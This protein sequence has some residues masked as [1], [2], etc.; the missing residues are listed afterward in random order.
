M[1]L[2]SK[3]STD[4]GRVSTTSKIV[5]FFSKIMQKSFFTCVNF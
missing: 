2:K 4:A 1:S 5:E 3:V